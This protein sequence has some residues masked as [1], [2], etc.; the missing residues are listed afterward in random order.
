MAAPGGAPPPARRGRGSGPEGAAEA[1]EGRP[2]VAVS[3]HL[4]L[5]VLTPNYSEIVAYRA[6]Y[7]VTG[8]RG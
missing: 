8:L 4:V 5:Y 1:G 2:V 6:V 3:A 7:D